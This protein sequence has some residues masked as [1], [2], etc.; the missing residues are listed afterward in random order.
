MNAQQSP[1]QAGRRRSLYHIVASVLAAITLLGAIA[2]FVLCIS[3]RSTVNGY[4]EKAV[5]QKNRAEQLIKE[6]GWAADSIQA[7]DLQ[8][9][10]EGP[11]AVERDSQYLRRATVISVLVATASAAWLYYSLRVWPQRL[12]R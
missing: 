1:G 2:I 6:R 8:I 10:L 3:M 4:L 12:S 7:Q 5:E 9:V 11:E